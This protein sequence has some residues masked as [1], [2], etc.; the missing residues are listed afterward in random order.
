MVKHTKFSY[1]PAI[2][3]AKAVI[4]VFYNEESVYGFSFDEFWSEFRDEIIPKLLKPN[5][6]TVLHL[7]I[8][9]TNSYIDDD[10]ND[11]LKNIDYKDYEKHLNYLESMIRSAG[12]TLKFKLP[13]FD[14]IEKCGHCRECESCNHFSNFIEELGRELI[15]IEPTIINTTFHLLM[16]NKSFLKDFHE[17]I[18]LYM[19]DDIDYI[20]ENYPS[21]IRI[22][23]RLKRVSWP[24][25][26]KRGIFYRDNGVCVV[27][28]S[29]L[30]GVV[31]IGDSF[32]LDHIV[33]LTSFGNNDSSNLQI[34]CKSCNINK[35]DKVIQ[36]SVIEVPLWDYH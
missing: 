35:S 3:L 13:D 21:Y 1:T 11:L 20:K 36:T 30:T 25:W 6:E 2:I 27:C 31:N 18:A 17:S 4:E 26:L 9:Y 29:D 33:P 34:L 14:E 23:N 19:E 8:K 5:K 12:I 32:E 7:Y 10:L 15:N 28:R 22:N 24:A 16:L